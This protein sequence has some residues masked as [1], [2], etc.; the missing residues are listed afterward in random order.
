[1]KI[2][3]IVEDAEM[4]FPC[5]ARIR[6]IHV[7]IEK[8]QPHLN[9][10][11]VAD[12]VFKITVTNILWNIPRHVYQKPE[13]LYINCNVIVHLNDLEICVDPSAK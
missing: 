8:R 7:F 12:I 4:K 3:C 1:M 11:R 10:L 9:Q 13:K 6:S 5:I 2:V